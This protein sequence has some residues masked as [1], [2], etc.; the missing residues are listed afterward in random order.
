MTDDEILSK[1]KP[2]LSRIRPPNF[3]VDLFGMIGLTHKSNQE[4]SSRN[5]ESKPLMKKN[6]SSK[7]SSP[8]TVFSTNC[9]ISL[10]ISNALVSSGIEDPSGTEESF[11]LVEL[12]I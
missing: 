4:I 2:P 3:R 10:A 9:A 5:S 8:V 11:S 1:T 12:T 7:R 6:I